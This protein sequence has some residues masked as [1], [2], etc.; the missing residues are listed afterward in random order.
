[1]IRKYWGYPA[2]I[3]GEARPYR[4][5]DRPAAVP[6]APHYRYPS[7]PALNGGAMYKDHCD[8]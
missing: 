5:A 1:M 6:V 8:A 4:Q 3:A 7:L 2:L